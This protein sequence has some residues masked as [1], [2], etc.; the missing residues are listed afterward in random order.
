MV[1]AAFQRSRFEGLQ[2]AG[3]PAASQRILQTPQ[4][5]HLPSDLRPRRIQPGHAETRG[6]S[7]VK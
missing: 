3:R 2:R 4:T 5:A 6:V 7:S 1:S